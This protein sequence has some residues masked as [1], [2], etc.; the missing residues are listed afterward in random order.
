MEKTESKCS[1]HRGGPAAITHNI[2][3]FHCISFFFYSNLL[4]DHSWIIN[5]KAQDLVATKK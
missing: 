2:T 4:S 3:D 5:K 1:C